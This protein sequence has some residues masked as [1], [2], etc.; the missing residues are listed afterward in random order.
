MIWVLMV[1]HGIVIAALIA[2]GVYWLSLV[3]VLFLVVLLWY[4]LSARQI[5]SWK[6]E[7]KYMLRQFLLL[8][9][10]SMIVVWI[11]SFSDIIGDQRYW[12]MGLI[13]LQVIL[14]LWSVVLQSDDGKQIFHRW[15]YL[16]SV[17]FFVTIGKDLDWDT[18]LQ[19]VASWWWLTIWLYAFLYYVLWT[20]WY[21]AWKNIGWLLYAYILVECIY[22]IMMEM[23]SSR[24]VWV[25][26]FMLLLLLLAWQTHVVSTTSPSVSILQ[27]DE[28]EEF[29][30][31]LYGEKE[32]V[33]SYS[34]N[35]LENTWIYK[36][37]LAPIL[38]ENK[39]LIASSIAIV[40]TVLIW[41][42]VIRSSLY[43]EWNK[44]IGLYAI[45]FTYCGWRLITRQRSDVWNWWRWISLIWVLIVLYLS[46][47]TVFGSNILYVLFAWIAVSIVLWVFLIYE[48][49]FLSIPLFGTEDRR[50][51][52]RGMVGLTIINTLLFIKLP[53]SFQLTFALMCMYL[54][55]QWV[56]IWYVMKSEN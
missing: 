21:Q 29:M 55:V 18:L 48:S 46:V 13:L 40:M 42:S 39:T 15:Y 36:R 20:V 44:L 12:T 11:W 26:I 22:V 16:S 27:D 5:D 14:W 32:H 53:F 6:S 25:L 1:R 17:L 9:A 45:L 35:G 31:L 41:L 30:D 49:N 8:G 4:S 28:E 33:P 38:S 2:L 23:W 52:M 34:S 43:I 50:V 7:W 3:P 19:L 10:W 24:M 54:G 51:W 37:W 56:L 47:V